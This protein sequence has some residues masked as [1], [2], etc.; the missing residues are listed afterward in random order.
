MIYDVL[1]VDSIRHVAEMK[2]ATI[3]CVLLAIFWSV[4]SYT[5]YP[6]GRSPSEIVGS[7]PT[8]TMDVCRSVIF[9]QVEVSATSWSLVQRSPT[10]CGASCV[11]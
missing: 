8:G 1:R 9:C 4:K 11:I 3:L 6:S 7:N 2:T 5:A 10:E